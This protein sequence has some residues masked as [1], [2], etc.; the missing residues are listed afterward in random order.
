MPVPHRFQV[1]DADHVADQARIDG[2]FQHPGI[3]EVA[4]IV[5]DGEEDAVLLDCLDDAPAVGRVGGHGFFQQHGVAFL[6]KGQGW[7]DV[8][9]V[10]GGDDDRVGELGPGGQGRPIGRRV[11]GRDAVLV[12]HALAV[13]GARFGYPHHA[14]QVGMFGDKTGETGAAASGA[15][16]NQSDGF[17]IVP[18]G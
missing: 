9:A 6:G 15:N 5:K 10:G 3:V 17:H 18:P 11:L 8:I 7:I 16:D 12:G 2:L 1:L 14:C 13:E 4:E